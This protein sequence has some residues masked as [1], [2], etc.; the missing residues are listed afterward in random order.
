MAIKE[1][2]ESIA[3]RRIRSVAKNEPIYDAEKAGWDAYGKAKSAKDEKEF[4]KYKKQ[5]QSSLEDGQ[6]AIKPWEKEMGDW[7]QAIK[8]VEGEIAAEKQ[9][10]EQQQK[11][12]DLVN[13][14]I[15]EINAEI[16][17]YNDQLL[18]GESDPRHRP[19]VPRKN[20]ALKLANATAMLLA[21]TAHVHEE[22]T[23]WKNQQDWV[24][25]PILRLMG[26]KDR[27]PKLKF[28]K[29]K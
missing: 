11:E 28:E 15:D 21:A 19:L 16:K 12:V 7:D 6:K 3:T 23:C 1:S 2:L 26:L 22:K 29:K 5:C 14:A 4:D 13:T 17:A 18:L 8:G 10:I 9:K 27:L 25:N 24:T 20:N